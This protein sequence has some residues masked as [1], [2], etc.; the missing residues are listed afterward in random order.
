MK[1]Q[2]KL[3]SKCKWQYRSKDTIFLN[4]EFGICKSPKNPKFSEYVP[5]FVKN[6]N[7]NCNDFEKKYNWFIKLLQL[8]LG[9]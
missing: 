6:N 2:K 7:E 5:C 8:L 1:E 3:C 9:Y 4:K